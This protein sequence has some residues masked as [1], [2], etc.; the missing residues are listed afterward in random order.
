MTKVNLQVPAEW[1]VALNTT[2]D[3]QTLLPQVMEQ[4]H[5]LCTRRSAQVAM[6]VGATDMVVRM[7]G[8]LE[9]LPPEKTLGVRLMALVHLGQYGS[10]AACPDQ[11]WTSFTEEDAEDACDAAFARGMAL[12]QLRRFED[13]SS[14]LLLARRLAEALGMR[15]RVQL[16]ALEAARLQTNRGTPDPNSLRS[17][18][19]LQPMSRRR[20]AWATTSLV[21]ALI[22]L[23]DYESGHML[24]EAYED[25][26]LR[27]LTSALLGRQGPTGGEGAYAE[28]GRSLLAL[29]GEN[30]S[31]QVPA[32]TTNSPQAEY[33]VLFRAWA[34]LR[35]RSMAPQAYNLLTALQVY[36][37]DQRAHRAA[38]LIQANAVLGG[39]DDIEQL[40]AE[41]NQALDAMTVRTSFLSLLRCLSA[42]AYALLGFLPKIHR[43]LSESLPDIPLL[44]GTSIAYRY[45]HIKLPGRASGSLVWV[46]AAAQGLSGR[47]ARPHPQALQRL[48][49]ALQKMEGEAS[50]FINLGTLV[51]VL[52]QFRDAARGVRRPAWNAAVARALGWLDSEALRHDLTREL[53]PPIT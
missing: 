18:M 26:G 39:G 45:Q 10:V 53:L 8:N 44:V 25:C 14:Q 31:F 15:H 11:P 32:V 34:M 1:D 9:A 47:E 35:T 46:N 28:I 16:V 48:R 21:E 12:V 13:A 5:L 24:L 33:A 3:V 29:R 20:H 22:A 51:R 52:V 17:A 19:G 6:A 27:V 30:E 7:L 49:E 40:V 43:D 36:T 2:P 4:E 38:A 41:F 42:D 50:Q 23:G 37:P